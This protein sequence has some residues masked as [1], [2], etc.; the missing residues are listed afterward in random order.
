MIRSFKVPARMLIG[1]FESWAC[2][3]KVLPPLLKGNHIRPF[4]D[5]YTKAFVIKVRP[6]F[7]KMTVVLLRACLHGGR[8]P[9]ITELP[10]ES[11]LFI[12]FFGKRIEAFTC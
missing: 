2:S 9:R 12:R 7:L 3:F 10:W 4:F 5:L 1:N 6:L 8:V 11:Q